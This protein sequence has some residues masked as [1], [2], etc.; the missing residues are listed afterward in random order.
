VFRRKKTEPI[1]RRLS[2][3]ETQTFVRSRTL[4]PLPEQRDELQTDRKREHELRTRRKKIGTVFAGLLVVVLA[5]AALLTQFV[6]IVSGLTTNINDGRS[7]NVA[8]YT[9]MANQY[10]ARRPFERFSFAFHGDAFNDHMRA[11]AVE[12][13]S[14]AIEK[15]AFVTGQL[16][17]EFRQPIAM[18]EVD[19]HK[20]YVDSE[21]VVFATN[22]FAEPTV[23]IID[24][25]G[26][27]VDGSAITSRRF[28]RFVGQVTSN[29]DASG[30]GR[31][32]SVTIPIAAV[33]YIEFRL[34]GRSY[35]IKA[36][37]DRDPSSQ[38]SDIV[39]TARYLDEHGIVPTYV[40][41]RVAG[42]SYW[43]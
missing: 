39:A 18:W 13:K 7:I 32:E 5:G 35:P 23:S 14:A 42:K 40:D 8:R 34:S 17:V 9:D 20:D 41:A 22:Y 19:G 11:A 3:D 6:S 37:I 12:I 29:V 16:H 1:R 10:F 26:V 38:A 15:N 4:T 25:S 27:S 28:L 30:V 21:G 31:V 2:V 24:N 33:R 36:Q 43:K